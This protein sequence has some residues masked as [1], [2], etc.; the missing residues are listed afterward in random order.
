M[1]YHSKIKIKIKIKLKL[2]NNIN[3]K[4]SIEILKIQ[5]NALKSRDPVAYRRKLSNLAIK[6]VEKMKKEG[7]LVCEGVKWKKT[8][9]WCDC[10]IKEV[11]ELLAIQNNKIYI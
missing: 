11:A 2:N 10:E 7:G 4:M 5:L 6:H 8:E 9:K 3:Y 1:N